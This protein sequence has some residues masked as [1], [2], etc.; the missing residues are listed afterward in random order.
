MLILTTTI[1][2]LSIECRPVAIDSG[3]NSAEINNA[4][5]VSRG[6]VHRGGRRLTDVF[7]GPG[8]ADSFRF[9]LV[10]Q[11][12]RQRP[13]V[14]DQRLRVY[15]TGFAAG[16][17]PHDLRPRSRITRRHYFTDTNDSL[18]IR[19]G[20]IRNKSSRKTCRVTSYTLGIERLLGKCLYSGK[21][22]RRDC[23]CLADC[24]LS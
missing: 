2:C 19:H 16:E 13:E 22:F 7:V 24:V 20:P 1:S 23:E 11:P 18:P 8:P 5:S 9:V 4:L 21:L 12:V 14:F 6:R 17:N 10:N 15:F 3:S